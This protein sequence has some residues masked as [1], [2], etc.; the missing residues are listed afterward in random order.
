MHTTMKSQSERIAAAIETWRAVDSSRLTLTGRQICGCDSDAWGDVPTETSVGEDI[1][2][3]ASLN[4]NP[5]VLTKFSEL[6]EPRQRVLRETQA[7]C[8]IGYPCIRAGEVRSVVIMTLSAGDSAVG[9][10]EKWSRDDRDELGL[11]AN[12]CANLDLLSKI[13]P[14]TKFPRGA[15]LPGQSWETRRPRLIENLAA[16]ADFMR[17]SSAR[18]GGI[19]VGLALPVMKTAHDLDS[20]L[21][22]LSATR[23]PLAQAFEIWRPTGNDDGEGLVLESCAYGPYIEL[24]CVSKKMTLVSDDD[25]AA[26]ARSAGE[27]LVGN[28]SESLDPRRCELAS[29]YG[30]EA[31]AAIPVFAGVELTSVV[32]L[33]W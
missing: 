10:V 12:Y 1:A 15:G 29:E 18:L 8:C 30:F 33:F 11:H 16:S 3:L 5:V 21:L 31:V 13:S 17:A 27:P 19:D 9:A 26:R 20:V 28:T 23:S 6:P 14:F 7:T 24:R 4:G 32:T 25:I 2:G 22:L